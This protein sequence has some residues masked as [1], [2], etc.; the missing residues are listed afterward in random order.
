[1]KEY[2][3]P[4][5]S[6][7]K[8]H[9]LLKELNT[10]KQKL[11]EYKKKLEETQLEL[12]ENNS[13][14]NALARNIDKIKLETNMKILKKLHSQ[15]LPI[16]KEIKRNKH[17]D[18]VQILADEAI[19][20]LQWIIPYPDNPYSTMVMLTPMEMRIASMIKD[21]FTSNDIARL[22]FI[23]LDTVKSHRSNIR[24]KLGL[25]NKQIDLNSYLHSLLDE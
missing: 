6:N 11:N 12:S 16:L 21:G 10:L 18:R 9:E 7:K 14:L 24:K 23:S 17:H 2:Q 3:I 4:F 22:Q 1:M 20:K 15:I 8:S 5:Q 25:K 19:A 13:A